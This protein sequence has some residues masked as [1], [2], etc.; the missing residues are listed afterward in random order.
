ML[1]DLNAIRT[2]QFLFCIGVAFYSGH[3]LGKSR[4]DSCAHDD[5]E[6]V[7]NRGNGLSYTSAGKGTGSVNPD[8]IDELMKRPYGCNIRSVYEELS[9]LHQKRV[10]LQQEESKG[11]ANRDRTAVIA[12]KTARAE[13]A[14]SSLRKCIEVMVP[15]VLSLWD[16]R[17]KIG[18]MHVT[19]KSFSGIDMRVLE[20]TADMLDIEN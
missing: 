7:V 9:R 17:E 18:H 6:K 12:S 8:E 15:E 1:C 2:V 4:G 16:E 19:K 13:A 10:R 3:S 11:Q 5:V 20:E 14:E